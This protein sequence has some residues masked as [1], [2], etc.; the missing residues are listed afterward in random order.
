[1]NQ[2]VFVKFC[3]VQLVPDRQPPLSPVIHSPKQLDFS[4]RWT[5]RFDHFVQFV[6]FSRGFSDLTHDNIVVPVGA[7]AEPALFPCFADNVFGV[8]LVVRVEFRAVWRR[9]AAYKNCKIWY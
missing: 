3:T 5:N 9:W 1:M 2:L 7:D 6:R 8:F 4:T